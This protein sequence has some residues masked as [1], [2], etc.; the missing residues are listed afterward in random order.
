M[1]VETAREK[2]QIASVFSKQFL[3]N[4]KTENLQALVDLGCLRS[5]RELSM[6]TQFL[7]QLH[8]Q[9]IQDMLG[10]EEEI[11]D[12]TELVSDMAERKS[13]AH[14][15][16]IMREFKRRDEKANEGQKGRDEAVAAKTRRQ[17]RRKCMREQ[18]RV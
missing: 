10:L 7:P 4:F 6:E 2:R 3:V 11:K 16:A 13:T 15:E 12:I 9:I 18:V 5:R 1:I 17:E 8:T 14:K